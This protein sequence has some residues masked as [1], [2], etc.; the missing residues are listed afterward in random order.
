MPLQRCINP[1]GISGWKWGNA[2]T[3]YVGARAKQRAI[4]Q[5]IAIGEGQ[6]LSDID[7]EHNDANE[8]N[9]ISFKEF[10]RQEIIKKKGRKLRIKR[11][12]PW[13]YPFVS[14]REYAKYIKSIMMQFAKITISE[15]KPLLRDWKNTTKQLLEDKAHKDEDRE[16]DAVDDLESI[17]EQYANKQKEIFVDDRIGLKTDLTLIALGVGA[18]NQ[19]QFQKT[20][21]QSIGITFEA[22]ETWEDPLVKRWVAENVN[23]IKGLSD[24]YIKQINHA[25]T[26]GITEGQTA[27]ALGK[28]LTKIN[29]EFITGRREIIKNKAGEPILRNG[30]PMFK[31][32]QSRSDLIA[33]DQ[34]GKLNGQ[35]TR[36]RQED[37]GIET[38]FWRTAGDERVRSR[39]RPLDGML[40][41]WDDVTVYSDDGGKTWKS[42]SSIGAIELHPGQDVQCRCQGEANW[43]TVVNE[44]EEEMAA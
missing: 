4:S 34:I 10:L 3:C 20:M 15:M 29:K 9:I 13:L 31:R 17:N 36:K 22:F 5:A 42:R 33:R 24:D 14:E 30:K 8:N 44:V 6:L 23:L 12:S 37:V 26:S 38:Y 40:C 21:K 28:Q 18:F 7:I 27:E 43:E 41:R 19:K 32:V 1:K 39:H 16:D 2:G 25:V 35:Y 11:P